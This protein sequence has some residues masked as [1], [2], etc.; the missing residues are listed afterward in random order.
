[1]QCL[2]LMVVVEVQKGFGEFF[3][4]EAA[5]TRSVATQPLKE[6]GIIAR[7][8]AIKMLDEEKRS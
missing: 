8:M 6:C 2:R 4:G 5:R 7:D 1:M 3:W